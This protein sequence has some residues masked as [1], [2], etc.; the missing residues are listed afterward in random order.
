MAFAPDSVPR[1]ILLI[2]NPAAGR[3]RAS[4]LAAP[5]AE[6]LRGRGAS[7]CVHTATSS[8]QAS[9]QARAAA[10]EFGCIAAVGGDGT[11][12]A[13]ATGV[14][15]TGVALGILPAGNG[16]DI[17]RGLGL[18]R[19]PFD[20]ARALVRHLP[21][22][23]DALC[24]CF[25][26]GTTRL[27]LGAGGVG[28]DSEA[29]RLAQERFTDVP[30]TIRYIAAALWAL[31]KYRPLEVKLETE[32]GTLDRVCAKVLLLAVA[33]GPSYGGGLRIAPQADM[34]DGQLDLVLVEPLHWS[35]I[36]EALPRLLQN[37]NLRYPE[38]RRFRTRRVHI[39]TSPPAVFHGDGELLGHTP[40]E[41]TVL[42]AAVPVVAPLEGH[43]G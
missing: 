11:V 36:I 35:R 37:G 38:L 29:A 6:F 15:G 16:N 34:C 41:I 26:D 42:P 23:V 9:R 40:V 3:G 22:R 39:M 32:N 1:K 33:N 24:A 14:F 19:D 13:V 12:N 4:R 10:G 5:V 18:P 8:E 30:G 43:R 21:K 7:V 28:L 31:G 27:Y 20:A 2:V 25:A 17:A